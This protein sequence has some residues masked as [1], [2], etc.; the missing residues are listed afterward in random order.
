MRITPSLKAVA[1]APTSPMVLW[2]GT[3]PFYA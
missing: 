1:L 3:V 2:V